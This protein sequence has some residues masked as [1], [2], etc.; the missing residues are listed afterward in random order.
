MYHTTDITGELI[1][2]GSGTSVG[3]PALGC[4]C[5]VCTSSDPRNRRLRSSVILGLPE[6]NL[7]IDTTPDLRTQLLREKIGIVHAVAFTHS[8]ADHLF[9]LDDV[10][11]FPLYLGHAMPLYCQADVEDQIRRSFDYAFTDLEPTHVGSVPQLSFV[12]IGDGPFEVLGAR[13]IPIPLTHGRFNVLGFRVGNVAYC[14][15]TNGI[16]A[17]SWP[18]LEGLDTLI[19]DA[20]RLRPHPTHF[21]L[22]E[23]IEAAR[24][25]GARQTYFT[26]MTH[27]LEHAETEAALP[28]GMAL[29][30]DGLHVPLAA[31][32][33]R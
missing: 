17:A 28:P 23:A 19:L 6:G 18:L 7:L 24:R 31:G 3:V 8:H 33:L 13:V 9:G 2:L 20:L 26:H 16:P 1:V 30:Y 27:D 22:D 14:T 4:G 29:A 12:R 11:L 5:P 10:R 21:S 25:I 15:D 32:T